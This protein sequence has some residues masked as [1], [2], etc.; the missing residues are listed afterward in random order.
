MIIASN[1][2]TNHT[3]AS[4]KAFIAS[5]NAYIAKE[6]IETQ[7]IVFP[8]ATGLDSFDGLL[9]IGTQNAYPITSGSC[10]GEIGLEQLDEFGIKTILIGHSERRTLLGESDLLLKAKFD[11]FKAHNFK[12][13]F[14]IGEPLE[15][16][17]QG[18][19]ATLAYL[20][21]QLEGIDLAYEKLIIA[22]EPIWAIG[23]G[24]SATNE[25]IASTHEALKAMGVYTLL[26]GGSV[27]ASNIE[28]ILSI[29]SVDGALIGTASWESDAFCEILNLS[30][31][32]EK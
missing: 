10:T 15:I 4:T 6:D 23:T 2:K 27:K 5:V 24:V 16:R 12:I 3:R 26:Y 20:K 32:I 8:T 25:Q 29:A 7:T 22:Y 17:E 1:F 9:E 18:L 31:R 30:K 19:D 14:C 28:E 11:F 21:N 13:V